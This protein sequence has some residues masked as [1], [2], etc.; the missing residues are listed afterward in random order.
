MR[1]L[2]VPQDVQIVDRKSGKPILLRRAANEEPQPWNI[3]HEDFVVEYVLP[4]PDLTKGGAMALR[5]ILKLETV[6]HGCRP[7]DVIPIEDADFLILRNVVERVEWSPN[8]ARYAVQMLP[9]LE[10]WEKAD[11]QNDAWMAARRA[12]GSEQEY[13][14]RVEKARQVAIETGTPIDSTSRG[15]AVAL[16]NGRAQPDEAGW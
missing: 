13:Q 6:L 2:I 8:F 15:A 11:A 3:S 4:H 16:E 1:Y 10:A 5:R 14:A 9:H 7:G 12:R